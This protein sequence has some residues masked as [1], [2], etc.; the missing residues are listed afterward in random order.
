MK[1]KIFLPLLI[2]VFV[3]SLLGCSNNKSKT[4]EKPTK[5]MKP[6]TIGVMPDLDS[7]PFII[8]KNNGYFEEEGVKV[9]IKHFK[10][11]VDRDSALQTGN[12]DGAVS[13][14]ISVALLNDKKFNIKMTSQTDGGFK[15]LSGKNSNIEKMDEIKGKSIGISKN[16]I[17]EYL[18]D[19]MTSTSNI[20]PD[21]INKVSVPQIP[22]R[23]EMLKN[24]KIDMAALP[25]PLASLAALDGNKVLSSSDALNINAGVLIFTQ[26]SIDTKKDEIKAFYRA[27]NKAVDYI[28][29]EKKEKYI[30]LVIKEA[31]FPPTVKDSLTLPKYTKATTPSK[32]EFEEV[33]KWVKSKNL[34]KTD[35]KFDDVSDS[36]LI[37]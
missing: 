18:T 20:N 34:I 19:R 3:V 28:G 17:I 7:V 6:I 22:T 9:D 23:L 15:L 10:S 5:D 13:D 25:E 4:E 33:L 21:T 1:K 14:M 16:T 29:K 36:S 2:I 24:G 27:Y 26:N 12:L 31:G 11:A 37:K 32:S 8:A 35:L 30:D